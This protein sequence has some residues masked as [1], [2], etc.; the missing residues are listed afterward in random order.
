MLDRWNTWISAFNQ[1]CTDDDWARLEPYLADDVIYVVAGAP[2]AC[3]IRGRDEVIAGFAKSIRNFD[4]HF[5][6]RRWYGVGIRVQEP[7]CVTGRSMG[8]YRL[9][10]HAPIT[11]S[12]ISQ[13]VFRG[14][15]I[16]VMT[17]VYDT[18]EADVVATMTRLAELGLD[19]D[20][21]YA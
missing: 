8:W 12:A 5:D 3:E 14:D 15:H 13:W 2:F 21:S 4:R 9:G 16:S 10:N 7:N 19:L 20:P 18:Q 17:D 6:E 1:S 11:F